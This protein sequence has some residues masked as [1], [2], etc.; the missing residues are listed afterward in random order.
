MALTDSLLNQIRKNAQKSDDN[1]SAITRAKSKIAL[2]ISVFAAIYSMNAFL[3]GQLSGKILNTTIE[4][5]DRAQEE[6][7]C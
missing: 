5:K 6:R 3:A 2:V 7:T 1:A 4:I